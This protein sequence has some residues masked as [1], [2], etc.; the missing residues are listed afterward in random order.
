M[1]G[2]GQIPRTKQGLQKKEREKKKDISD[3]RRGERGT[4]HEGPR[5]GNM[6]LPA[7]NRKPHR[8]DEENRG[9]KYRN[10]AKEKKG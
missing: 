2:K 5:V 3:R 9:I 4:A 1:R 10:G 6:R 8:K 7:R